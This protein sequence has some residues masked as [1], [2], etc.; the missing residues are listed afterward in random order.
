MYD[1]VPPFPEA[2]KVTL[3]P[4]SVGFCDDETDT[5]GST[6]TVS[7]N[8]LDVAEFPMVSV[9]VTYM[10]SVPEELNEVA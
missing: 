4:M 6:F 8:A 3:F 10:E 7:V 2:V 1:P 5:E 9:I